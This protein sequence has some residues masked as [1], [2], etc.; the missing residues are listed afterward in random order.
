MKLAKFV[1]LH[2]I[3][4]LT[5]FSDCFSQKNF[6]LEIQVYAKN[7]KNN[8]KIFI[9]G[10]Q[11]K[12]GNWKPNVVALKK[13][14]DSTWE[15]KEQ[16]KEN[17]II[18]FKF[19]LGNWDTEAL[20]DKYIPFENFKLQIKKDTT[21][22]FFL[23]NWKSKKEK[24]ENGIVW[25]C[26]YIKD[27]TYD[28]L[29]KRDIII[30]LPPSY[31]IEKDKRYP[32]LYM[33]DGQNIADPNTSAFG[34]DWRIDEVADSLVKNGEMEEII[35]VGI[36]NTADRYYEYS[37]L[38]KGR[39]YVEAI[40][41]KLKPHIDSTYRTLSDRENTAVMGASMGGLISLI[42]AWEYSEYFSKAACLSPALVYK[43]REMDYRP[44]LERNDL[45][46]NPIK[47]YIDNGGLGVDS[48]LQYGVEKSVEILKNK[49]NFKEGENLIVIYDP[50]AEH[51]ELAWSRRI[52]IPLK[53]FFR[54]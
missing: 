7:L 45:P 43:K 40:I 49:K 16:F 35:I 36:Y 3:I 19:T 31:D 12:L 32:V 29:L 51:N 50:T 10:N 26:E 54:N 24:I 15:F 28:D 44:W 23:S 34:Q 5:F 38:D 13:L 14:N 25:K 42:M 11:D 9:T 46:K 18:E 6:F 47:L 4:S 27:F 37:Y 41:K 30:L 17:E 2:V 22:K 33:H 39:K 53:F 48:L 1:L 8:E 52:H 20:N 21:M